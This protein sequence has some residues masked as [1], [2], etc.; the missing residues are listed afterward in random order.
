MTR[1]AVGLGANLGD[2]A[3]SVG[4]AIRALDA[5]PRTRRVAASRL[6]RSTAWGV[7]SQPDFVNAVAVFDTALAPRELLDALLAIDRR[8]GRV[9]VDGERWGPRTLD[10]DLLLHGDAEIDEG[11]QVVST[12]SLGL[13]LA[14]GVGGLPRLQV[15][16]RYS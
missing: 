1:A 8:F 12:G 5:L 11:L 16:P 6:Y 10:L 7:T 2:A 3:A 15:Y 4:A 9:R 14:L 13:D